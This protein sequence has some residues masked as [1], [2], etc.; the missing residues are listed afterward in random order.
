MS[1]LIKGILEGRKREISKAISLV[2]N[3][4]S[5]AYDILREIH[6]YTGRSHVVGI[7][8]PPGSGKSTLINSLVKEFRGKGRKIGIIAIDPSSEFTGGAFLGDRVRMQSLTLDKEVF[9]RSM[10][11]RGFEGGVAR[12]AIYAAKVLEASGKDLII[13]ET[14]GVGQNEIDVADAVHTVVVL[15]TPETGDEIQVLKAGYMEIG[16]IYVV[17]KADLPGSDDM[18]SEIKELTK[19]IEDGWRPPVIKTVALN[20]TG[21]GELADSIEKHF[22]FLKGTDKLKEIELR[23]IRREILEAAVEKVKERFSPV[24]ELGEGKNLV[25][26]VF[27]REISPYVAAEILL[28]KIFKD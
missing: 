2:E 4:S 1:N 25:E 22:I 28:K 11:T 9:I 10:A 3:N 16:D 17:N 24:I 7:T 18:A 20:G 26:K 13:I 19:C 15:V 14:V 6:R 21:I 27:S 23:K 5:R 8:G 12:A